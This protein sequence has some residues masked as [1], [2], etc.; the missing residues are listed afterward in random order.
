MKKGEI[1][2]NSL[3]DGLKKLVKTGFFDIFGATII[4]SI[5]SFVYGIFIVRVMSTYDYGIFSYIQN[6]TNFAVMFCSLG[7]NLGVLQYCSEKV[8][9]TLKFSYCR[10]AL[11]VGT[12]CS[13]AMVG[14]MVFYT[15]IDQSSFE[16]LTSYILQ[17][18]FLPFLYF[19]KE[20]ITFNLRWQLKNRQY[21]NVLNVHS[22]T[23]AVFAV[24][25]A[26]VGGIH[27]VIFGIYLAYIC[28]I[29]LGIKYLKD[30]TLQSVKV[31]KPLEKSNT[32]KFMKYSITM[33]IV[34]AMISVLYTIDLFV[35]GNIVQEA[36]Q[37]A[38]Y[39]TACVIP[40]ALNMIPNSIMT[41]V[42]PHVANH[43]DDKKWMKKNIRL[44]YIANGGINLAIGI[45]LYVAAPLII[46]I[47]FGNKYEGI[48][49]VFRIMVFSYIVSSCLRTPAA[50]LFGILRKT[51]TAFVVS[52]CTVVLSVCLGITLVSRLGIIGAAYG[53]VCTF[54]T[55]GIASSAILFWNVYI[56]Q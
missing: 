27:G 49:P 25:G 19:L 52:A 20:W 10:L 26:V 44:L 18:S 55:V 43:K 12:V 2:S 36:E 56:K 46:T 6:I 39:K 41:F 33:C 5:V 16:N 8:E 31:G 38:M 34:N 42:Y 29:I 45:V 17:F 53:S 32:K 3:F 54:A 1:Q 48:L 35:I 28:A 30:G 23:N 37:V 24:L 11:R 14:I 40:F 9:N 15:K 4:N 22:F 21:A 13:I 50:N 7:V 47:L 51:K